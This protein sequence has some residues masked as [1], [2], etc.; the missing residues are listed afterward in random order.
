MKK[1]MIVLVCVS[2]IFLS[3]LAIAEP[4]T[5]KLSTVVPPMAAPVTK[6][7]KPWAEKINNESQ[8]SLKIEIYAG[9]VLGKNTKMYLQQIESGVFDMALIYPSYFGGR[10]SVLDFIYV[11]FTAENY[12]EGALAVQH[13]TDEGLINVFKDFVVI[14][15]IGT[16]PFYLN[17]TF[18][19]RMP[20]DVKGHKIRT[21]NKL[22]S[23]IISSLGATPFDMAVNQTAENLSRKLIEGTIESPDSL[24]IFGSYK[25]AKHHLRVPLGSSNLAIV[26]NKKVYT[27]LPPKAKAI[28]DK[29][30]GEYMARFWAE[31]LGPV[32]DHIFETWQKDPSRTIVTPTATEME[33]WKK[34]IHPVVV[35]WEKSNPDA[36]K[37]LKAYEAELSKIR[38]DQ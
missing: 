9:G 17:T 15:N 32:D 16:S 13:L 31:Q 35:N 3:A 12:I 1:L 5:L 27:N 30:R 8:G 25:I 26:M 14:M 20:D 36:A 23:E 21:A 10:F 38:S 34:A 18:P 19:V 4:I 29:Y 7:M 33:A 2:F 24:T 6:V 11:P 28:L 22:Q 37:L